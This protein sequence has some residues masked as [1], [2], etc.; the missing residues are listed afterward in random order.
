MS[1]SSAS[2]TIN[3]SDVGADNYTGG[4]YVRAG[5]S[6][7]GNMFVCVTSNSYWT[8]GNGGQDTQEHTFNFSYNSSTGYL[9]YGA[10]RCPQVKI[11]VYYVG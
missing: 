5:R 9:S 11:T 1:V 8:Y 2:Y 6:L 3:G 4:V 7:N 10:W